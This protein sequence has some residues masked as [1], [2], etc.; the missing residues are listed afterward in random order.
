MRP[1]TDGPGL[2]SVLTGGV[3]LGPTPGL[4][5]ELYFLF[6]MYLDPELV[7]SWPPR[8]MGEKD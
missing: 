2:T 4:R 5:S 6:S 7:Q 3:P 8:G 1:G